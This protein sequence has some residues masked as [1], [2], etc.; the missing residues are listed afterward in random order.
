MRGIVSESESKAPDSDRE[1]LMLEYQAPGCAD[2]PDH[3]PPPESFRLSS[4]AQ[5]DD[6]PVTIIKWVIGVAFII[7]A[8]IVVIV[9]NLW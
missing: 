3:L 2:P 4:S 6:L 8:I 5:G 7:C 9:V 1:R